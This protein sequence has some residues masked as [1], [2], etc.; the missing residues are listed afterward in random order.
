MTIKEAFAKQLQDAQQ[1]GQMNLKAFVQALEPVFA[2]EGYRQ[3]Q[4]DSVQQILVIR[5]DAIGDNVLNSGFL[6]ELRRNCPKA[7]ITLVVN[8][9]VY[10]LVEL[11]PY[12]NEILVYPG[13]SKGSF[14]ERYTWA[15]ELCEQ[16]LWQRHF[17]L[18]I[19]PRW[20]FDK[21]FALFLG[22]MSG[23]RERA[24]YSEKLYA[25]KA[26]VNAGYDDFLTKA[27]MNPP[28]LLHEVE[29]NLF[30]LKALG[31]TV[32]DDSLELWYSPA[33]SIKAGKLL[34]GFGKG[35]RLVAVALGANETNKA[36]PAELYAEAL[37]EIAAK[38]PVGFIL[39][40]GPADQSAGNLIV[41]KLPEG[42]A[43][44]LSGKTSLRESAAV[45]A[46]TS[47]YIGNDTGLTHMA[48][49]L[50]RVILEINRE[51][52]DCPKTI[53]SLYAR[54]F[55]WQTPAIVLRPQKAA[56]NC[57]SV[58]SQGG[59]VAGEPHC[60]KKILPDD[61]MAAYINLQIVLYK[62]DSHYYWR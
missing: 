11:C 34:H 41:G 35:K 22:Y 19:C 4:K 47:V 27:V 20:D 46:R 10:N 53:I 13:A 40:G 45:L 50:K 15:M 30:L 7:Q 18:C 57:A 54:F 48:A 56:G 9:V 32:Q 33:D 1:T 36:Y 12:V 29:R 43:M 6:R 24:G 59:C 5:L 55:P 8:P 49:A 52:E 42:M 16:K 25:G 61:I 28:E 31:M 60:I 37:A 21:Y 14:V 62:T 17:D 26:K 58:I 39:L 23:A 2:A 44:D 3:K 51:A 38:Y